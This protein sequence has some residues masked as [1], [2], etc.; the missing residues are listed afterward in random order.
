[1]RVL[2]PTARPLP[3]TFNVAVSVPPVVASVAVPR[4][5]V[6]SLKETVPVGEAVPE[7]GLMVAVNCVVPVDA[8]LVGFAVVA[9]V[10]ATGGTVTLTS[11]FPTSY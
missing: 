10:V 4:E 6:P 11:P 3:F 5:V 8:M 7:A 1:M 2:V 9:M